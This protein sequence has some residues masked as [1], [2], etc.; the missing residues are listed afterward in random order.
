M[1]TTGHRT[2]VHGA[3]QA[4]QEWRRIL[5]LSWRHGLAALPATRPEFAIAAGSSRP[6]RANGGDLDQL[7]RRAPTRS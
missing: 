6:E 3:M 7:A 5:D 2:N 4:A 1:R